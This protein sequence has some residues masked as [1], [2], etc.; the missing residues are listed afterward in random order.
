MRCGA[1]TACVRT[2]ALRPHNRA[3]FL[4]PVVS[5]GHPMPASPARVQASCTPYSLTTGRVFSASQPGVLSSPRGFRGASH[6]SPRRPVVSLSNGSRGELEAPFS[7]R[8]PTGAAH[9]SCRPGPS[10]GGR[11]ASSPILRLTSH[12]GVVDCSSEFGGLGPGRTS[13]QVNVPA[14]GATAANCSFH[15]RADCKGERK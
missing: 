12:P 5:A 2:D 4:R 13:L 7:V 8:A 9:L 3:F 11:P 6:A 10:A 1:I 14:K 15:L